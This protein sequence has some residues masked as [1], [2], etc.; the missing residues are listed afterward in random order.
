LMMS[1]WD[2]LRMNMM[3]SY[4]ELVRTF[5]KK[6]A[7]IY[8]NINIKTSTFSI[9]LAVKM[10]GIHDANN[11]NA[12]NKNCNAFFI[13]P[14]TINVQLHLNTPQFGRTYKYL[15]QKKSLT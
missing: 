15:N 7:F 9:Y 10:M 11:Q 2:A 3:I 6:R 13:I 1:L 14:P 4:Q 5:P 12:T 8:P